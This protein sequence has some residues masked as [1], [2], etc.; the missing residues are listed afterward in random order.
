M[1]LVD[2]GFENGYPLFKKTFLNVSGFR[3]GWSKCMEITMTHWQ[4]S[5]ATDRCT[6]PKGKMS[7][8]TSKPLLIN[9]PERFI[10]YMMNRVSMCCNI[11]PYNTVKIGGARG[12]FDC[13]SM[14]FQTCQGDWQVWYDF[15]AQSIYIAHISSGGYPNAHLWYSDSNN[16]KKHGALLIYVSVKPNYYSNSRVSLHPHSWQFASVAGAGHTPAGA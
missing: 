11:Y 9:H 10:R 13:N 7:R 12:L 16:D 1:A 15:Q 5:W 3:R 2:L 14:A 8:L 6:P 4:S